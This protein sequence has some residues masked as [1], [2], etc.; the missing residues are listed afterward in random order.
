MSNFGFL[1]DS[2]PNLAETAEGAERL[3][4]VHPQ[5][6]LMCARQSL[7][8]LVFWLY[9]YDKKL[10]QPYDAS[11]HTLLGQADFKALVPTYVWDKM[12]VIRMAGNQAVHGKSFNK[13]KSEEAPTYIRHLFLIYTWFERN[14]GSPTKDRSQPSLFNPAL[15]AKA[16]DSEQ[17][18]AS[19]EQLQQQAK[20]LEQQFK[21]KYDALR[22]QEQQLL[23]LSA[24]LEEREKLLATIDADLA[25]KRQQVE[26]AKLANSGVPDLTDYKESETRKLKIDLM[27]KEAGWDFGSNIKIEVPVTGMPSAAGVGAVDY[28]LYDADGLPLAVVEAKRTSVDPA[29]GQQ[30]AKLY[31]DCLTGRPVYSV[32]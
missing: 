7:E 32:D 20:T 6:A 11:L 27:L 5:A 18:Q 25:Q 3:V 31:A 9:Q 28:V 30:Q 23:E 15:I 14:Y 29:N 17:V 21:A 22:V 24:S 1:Q 2:F 8:S 4:Y 26:Q 19:Q 12:D 10:S 16:R 13:I